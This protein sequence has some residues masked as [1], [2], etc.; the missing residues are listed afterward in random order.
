[1][2]ESCTIITLPPNPLLAEINNTGN[3]MPAILREEH[4]EA[5]LS[6]TSEEAL[7]ALQPYPQDRMV[8]WPVSSRVNSPQN[9]D[10]SLTL[11]LP[12][13]ARS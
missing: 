12:E 4:H 2:V 13:P 9:D 10:R 5:W 7:E 1:M 8:A 6:G 3:R 11:P